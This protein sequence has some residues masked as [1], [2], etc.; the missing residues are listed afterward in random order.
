MPD[1]TFVTS[2]GDEFTVTAPLGVNLMRAALDGG[3]PGIEGICGG[4]LV[5]ATCVCAI[6][7]EWRDRIAPAE[8]GEEEML[9]FCDFEPPAMRLSCQIEMREELAGM[10]LLVPEEQ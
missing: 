1:V 10:R 6:P 8:P 5:C 3:V 4:A 9:G 7:E 2:N